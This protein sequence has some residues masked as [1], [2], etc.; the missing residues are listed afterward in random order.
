[1]VWLVGLAWRLES[2]VQYYIEFST[3]EVCSSFGEHPFSSNGLVVS[4]LSRCVFS[5]SPAILFARCDGPEI[6]QARLS[7][8]VSIRHLYI[9]A[10]FVTQGKLQGVSWEFL[11]Y[12]HLPYLNLYT[13][14]LN[15][16]P[17]RRLLVDYPLSTMQMV[18]RSGGLFRW[19]WMWLHRHE[20][21]QREESVSSWSLSILTTVR[22][23]NWNAKEGEWLWRL[24]A[25]WISKPPKWFVLSFVALHSF[26]REAFGVSFWTR[27]RLL[28]W[29]TQAIKRRILCKTWTPDLRASACHNHF[30]SERAYLVFWFPLDEPLAFR[31][32][33]SVE[34][35]LEPFFFCSLGSASLN[36]KVVCLLPCISQSTRASIDQPDLWM[37]DLKASQAK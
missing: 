11:H 31:V 32:K 4:S 36:T 28:H 34:S 33:S 13:Y 15:T 23:I 18:Q 6:I 1:M 9:S 17:F 37:V 24:E 14:T 22:F 16:F 19:M 25:P 30:S 3:L 2:S 21:A 8:Y 20:H 10:K 27:I 26:H 7:S 5:W 12:R 29:R 35:G